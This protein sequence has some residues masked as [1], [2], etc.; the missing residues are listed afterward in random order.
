MRAYSLKTIKEMVACYNKTKSVD[1]VAETLNVLRRDVAA[2]LVWLHAHDPANKEADK[3]GS[4]LLRLPT[5]HVWAQ[6]LYLHDIPA[7]AAAACVNWPL[8][9]LLESCGGPKEWNKHSGRKA[10]KLC[11]NDIW[12]GRESFERRPEDPDPDQIAE[13]VK[14]VRLGWGP[15]ERVSRDSD[16]ACKRVETP[17]YSYDSKTGIF[18]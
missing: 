1:K 15:T 7:H 12:N 10:I 16:T 18:K 6:F 8:E 11:K 9:R 4:F 13:A 2:V 17:A 14:A 3:A 5:S